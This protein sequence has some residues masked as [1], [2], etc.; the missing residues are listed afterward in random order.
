MDLEPQNKQE[1]KGEAADLRLKEANESA[2]TDAVDLV[3]SEQITE[4]PLTLRTKPSKRTDKFVGMLV[5]DR[6]E[7]LSRI[8]QGATTSVYQARDKKLQR[9]VAIKILRSEFVS[10]ENALQRFK[11]ECKTLALLKHNNIVAY[12]DDGRIDDEQPYLVMEFLEGLS[13]KQLLEQSGAIDINRVLKITMQACAA[14][15]AAHEMGVIHRDLKPANI[16]LIKNDS[17]KEIV[18]IL[19]FG[20][21]KV[22]PI[23]GETFQTRTQTGEILG[24]LLYMSPEQCLDH[25]LDGRSDL[26]S[27][28]CVMFEMLTGSPPITARTAFET[29]NK[30]LTQMPPA[31]SIVRPEIAW[32]AA[33]NAIVQ[34]SVAKKP[35]D[36]Y[37][38]VMALEK[39]LGNFLLGKSDSVSSATFTDK[40]P[41]SSASKANPDKGLEDLGNFAVKSF[42]VLDLN[43]NGFVSDRELQVYLW[44]DNLSMQTKSFVSFLLNHRGEIKAASAE[45]SSSSNVD[46]YYPDASSIADGITRADIQAYFFKGTTASPPNA[47]ASM[48]V[49]KSD[50]EP[51]K[52]IPEAQP[53]VARPR[54]SDFGEYDPLIRLF[55]IGLFVVTIFSIVLVG[56]NHFVFWKFAMLSLLP[57]VLYLFAVLIGVMLWEPSAMARKLSGKSPDKG[58]K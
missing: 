1:I 40:L 23:Q 55:C 30:H 25:D 14:L 37:A 44:R 31:L 3:V 29:M 26:Y 18:K 34:R 53:A 24:T 21:S 36:R 48:P 35:D 22:L 13:L 32:P 11:Q 58:N 6:F 33:L 19:D 15:T 16:M 9:L 57:P 45:P 41:K 47:V 39:D 49:R 5:G 4:Q 7:I 42:D 54:P 56:L 10:S 46:I 50:A 38:S 8:G 28:G 51:E 52:E 12:Y 2:K 17:D 43:G 27:L 20:V